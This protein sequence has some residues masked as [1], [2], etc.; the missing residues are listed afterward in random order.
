MNLHIEKIEGYRDGGT[1]AI[2]TNQ[3]LYC[4]DGRELSNNTPNKTRGML[5][6]GYPNNSEPL[7]S[8]EAKQIKKELKLA[9]KEF[10]M[11]SQ[12]YQA[13]LPIIERIKIK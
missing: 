1:I 6:F 3:G 8:T 5:F 11:L 4:V 12:N 13:Y 7:E 9:L 2:H 10:G